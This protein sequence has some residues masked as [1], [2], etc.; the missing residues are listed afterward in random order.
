MMDWYGARLL[1]VI[2]VDDGKSRKRNHYDES[3]I[4]FRARNLDHAFQRAL[5]L[6]HAKETTYKNHLDQDVRWAFVEISAVNCV[7]KSIDGKEV[8]SELHSRTSSQPIPFKRRFVPGRSKPSI[9]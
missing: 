1:F 9:R 7:G 2:L 3:V 4:V 6:G 5:E 8:V